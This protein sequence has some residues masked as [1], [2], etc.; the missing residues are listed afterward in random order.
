M[1]TES[2]QQTEMQDANALR[3]L[4]TADQEELLDL[5]DKFR[6]YRLNE[7]VDLP[8][9]V[10]CGK[11]SSGKSS[12]LEA[13]SQL[14]FPRG[15]KACTTFATELILR[16]GHPS[17]KVSIRPAS[18]GDPIEDF[19]PTPGAIEDFGTMINE[20]KRHLMNQH[21]GS[22]AASI[23]EETLQIE[24]CNPHW[25]PLTLVDLPGLI[26]S[27]NENQP[28]ADIDKIHTLVHGYMQRPKTVILAVVEAN[29]D[30]ANQRVLEMAKELDPSRS[31]T[32]GII[33]KPDKIVHGSSM[34]REFV[35]CAQ[36]KHEKYQFELGWHVVRNRDF[37]EEGASVEELEKVQFG[38]VSCRYGA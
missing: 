11:Q 19:Q 34:E 32:M 12:V 8:E 23:F 22:F 5:I 7:I 6:E 4:L 25:P 28:K 20:A 3:Q 1:H 16:R 13:I 2:T 18:S 36:N 10:V 21:R 29:D 37:N 31:R 35:R 30:T 33:T 17:V 24:V 14:T 27:T 38:P 9:L 15:E 26:Q